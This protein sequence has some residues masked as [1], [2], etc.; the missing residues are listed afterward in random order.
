[1]FGAPPL[2]AIAYLFMQVTKIQ[3]LENYKTKI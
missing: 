2:L 1:M 3:N